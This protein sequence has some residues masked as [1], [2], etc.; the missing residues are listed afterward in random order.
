MKALV[1]LVLSV[2]VSNALAIGSGN[3][4]NRRDMLFIIKNEAKA[5]GVKLVVN[6]GDY[7]ET[8][9]YE[10]TCET[11]KIISDWQ[12]Q[13]YLHKQWYTV[14]IAESLDSDGGDLNDMAVV[15]EKGNVVAL[16]K[17]VPAFNHVL[18]AMVGGIGKL[19]EK[20]SQ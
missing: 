2:V 19:K 10:S 12:A 18:N 9:G 20:E 8:L 14:S 13:V 7:K 3:A 15:N 16:R 5:C 4:G 1:L 11:L 6:K 17:N